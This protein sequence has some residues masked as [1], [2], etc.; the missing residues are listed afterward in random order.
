MRDA[1][2]DVQPSFAQPVIDQLNGIAARH[3]GLTIS[4]VVRA[5]F[6]AYT[7][8]ID[9]VSATR[10]W[11][12]ETGGR[13]RVHVRLKPALATQVESQAAQSKLSPS[14]LV[15]AVVT[16]SLPAL[17]RADVR[18]LAEMILKSL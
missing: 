16:L 1:E 15:E 18:D 7:T 5:L 9:C 12:A 4:Q 14:K 10:E 17:E 6:V 11:R 13:Q 3:P 8:H 2:I